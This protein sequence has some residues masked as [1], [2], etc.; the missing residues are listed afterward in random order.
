MLAKLLLLGLGLIYSSSALGQTHPGSG[1]GPGN[2]SPGPKP[3][4]LFKPPP[5]APNQVSTESGFTIVLRATFT[6]D[7]T[8][9]NI[10]FVKV[11]PKDAPKETVKL[12]KQRAIE[13]AK[14]IKFIPATKDGRLVSMY[15]QLEYNFSPAGE[16]KPEAKTLDA[17]SSKP[18][19]EKPRV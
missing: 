19:T 6:S 8:V 10:R 13:A 15:M 14:Q 3:R 1:I 5:E 16:E 17:E 9:T 11:V 18:K 2:L 7:A 4:I 12:F